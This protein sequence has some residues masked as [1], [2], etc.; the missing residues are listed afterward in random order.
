M[1][2]NV[3][4]M[5]EMAR[6]HVEAGGLRAAEVYYRMILKD[7]T[8][9]TSG[10]ERLACG[11]AC[12]FYAARALADGRHGS[13][14]DWYQRAVFADPAAIDYR[15]EYVV[16]VLL[17]MGMFKNAKIEATGYKPSF[18]LDDGIVELMKGFQML[19]DSR[20]A[21]V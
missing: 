7:T 6:T 9:P 1:K 12:R 16:R 13:A 4:R 2:Q 20:Y 17:P 18:S 8:P 19:R 14:A 3:N 15:V 21:N 5:V 11:E 10:W